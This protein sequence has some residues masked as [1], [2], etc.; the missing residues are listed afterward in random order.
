MFG[1]ASQCS[2]ELSK[3]L[4]SLSCVRGFG[5]QLQQS[6]V[7]GLSHQVTHRFCSSPFGL[8][9]LVLPQSLQAAGE[10]EAGF[11]VRVSRPGVDGFPIGIDRLAIVPLGLLDHSTGQSP[12]DVSVLSFWPIACEVGGVF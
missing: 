3:E 12:V 10:S 5:G 8:G 11:P 7:S 6:L 9:Q 1:R 4:D 2:V